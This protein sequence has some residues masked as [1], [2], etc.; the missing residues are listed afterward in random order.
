M[1]TDTFE[2]KN[3]F[4]GFVMGKNDNAKL[5]VNYVGTKIMNVSIIISSISLIIFGVYVWKKH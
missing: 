5:E 1:I 3:G 4:I 2:T